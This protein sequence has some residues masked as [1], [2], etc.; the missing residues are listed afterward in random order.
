MARGNRKSDNVTD[1]E[2]AG[3]ADLVPAFEDEGLVCDTSYRHRHRR[4]QVSPYPLFKNNV[5]NYKLAEY[6]GSHTPNTC[7]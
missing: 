7:G 5:D 4:R 6:F 2:L 3:L 1:F